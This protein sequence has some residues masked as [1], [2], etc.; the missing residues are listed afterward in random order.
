MSVLMSLCCCKSPLPPATCFVNTF[1]FLVDIQN[2]SFITPFGDSIDVSALWTVQNVQAIACEWD[3]T[4]S[5]GQT[6]P[7]NCEATIN[8]EPFSCAGF[9]V[10]LKFRFAADFANPFDVNAYFVKISIVG[11]GQGSIQSLA[12]LSG[13]NP[14]GA[15][16][17]VVPDGD[18]TIQSITVSNV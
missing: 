11:G 12:K 4:G 7:I 5:P 14:T 2:W 8:G 18:G 9:I 10:Q 13:A 16:T 15:Y 6:A 3:Y 1:E 17:T